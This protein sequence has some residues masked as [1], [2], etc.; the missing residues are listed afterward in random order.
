MK[1][2]LCEKCGKKEASVFYRENKNGKET[3][4]YLCPDCAKEL[5][6]GSFQ[7]DFFSPFSL[8]APKKQPQSTARCPLCGT[9]LAQIRRDGK[10]GCSTCYDTFA[11]QLD[12]SPFI[13]KGYDDKALPHTPEKEEP[14]ETEKLKAELKEAVAKE[15]YERAA[16]LRDK[17]REQ[18]G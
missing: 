16:V 14:N 12:L 7:E 3:R 18:E 13:G 8:F 2:A 10:F 11:H 4:L 5:G 6:I 15:D 9:T 1:Q 17:I